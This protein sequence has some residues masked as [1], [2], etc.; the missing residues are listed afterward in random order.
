MHVILR[1]PTSAWNYILKLTNCRRSFYEIRNYKKFTQILLST[2]I[3][4][5]RVGLSIYDIVTTSSVNP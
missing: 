1:T 5:D 2:K 4:I 3:R